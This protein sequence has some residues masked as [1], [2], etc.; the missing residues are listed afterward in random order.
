MESVAHATIA[1]SRAESATALPWYLIAMIASSTCI[2]VGILWDISWHFSIGRD[3]FFSPPHG[4]VY[5]GG[6]L[7]GLSSGVFAIR[8]T[9]SG[10]PED[11]EATVR[12]WGF[13]APFGT[14]VTVWGCF[15]M[16]VSA[17]YDN[18]WH[19]AYGLDIGAFTPPHLLLIVGIFCIQLGVMLLALSF[20]NRATPDERIKLGL[21]HL[22]TAGLVL[23]LLIPVHVIQPNRRHG[24]FFYQAFSALLPFLLVS[25]ARSSR[26]RWAA[27][28]C[29][30]VYLVVVAATA[31][32]IIPLF[33]ATPRLGPVNM[34][35]THMA[36][37]PFPLLLVFPGLAIDFLLQ[38]R[39]G[40]RA[41]WLDALAMGV[42]FCVIFFVVHW[43]FAEFQ[44]S[45]GARNWFFGG[46]RFYPYVHRQGPMDF[47]FWW[48]KEDP[49]TPKIFGL[50]LLW[51]ILSTRVG[52][53]W[54]E[55]MSKVRR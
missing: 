29:A 7:A 15:A 9:F 12:F 41:G 52:L 8:K 6:L 20:Q 26:M 46:D 14:W 33:P 22:Y 35:I 34:Q 48:P 17:P 5:F 23:A 24:G 3:T 42:A 25:M 27:T 38:R 36:A 37:L 13:R 45:P 55:W 16:L 11:Q 19:D 30:S 47:K 2:M 39:E 28:I 32:W 44:L 4:A 50:A 54:G 31:V 18:W 53:W 40:K 49:M 10:S 43:Y 51:S 1:R 21:A